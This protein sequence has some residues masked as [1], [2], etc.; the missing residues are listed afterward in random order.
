MVC[1]SDHADYSALRTLLAETG[2]A[3]LKDRRRRTHR[4]VGKGWG[5][6]SST[7]WLPESLRDFPVLL[8]EDLLSLHRKFSK[9]ITKADG[10]SL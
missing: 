4:C 6:A 3:L 8:E 7:G 1:L 10:V 9:F 5:A 2:P